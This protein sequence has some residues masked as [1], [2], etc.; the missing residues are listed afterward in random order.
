M[1][2]GG[3]PSGLPIHPIL[4]H[5]ENRTEATPLSERIIQADLRSARKPFRFKSDWGW[6]YLLIAPTIIGLLILNIYPFFETII[7]KKKKRKKIRQNFNNKTGQNA[8]LNPLES[9]LEKSNLTRK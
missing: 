7:K 1:K 3:G 6:A 4:S 2:A 9:G 8:A 5:A